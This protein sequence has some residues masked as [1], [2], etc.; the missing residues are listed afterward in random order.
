MQ[1]H[2]WDSAEQLRLLSSSSPHRITKWALVLHSPLLRVPRFWNSVMTS[3]HKG[4]NRPRLF[5]SGFLPVYSA[6]L[7]APSF[8]PP[9]WLNTLDPKPIYPHTLSQIRVKPE[10]VPCVRASGPGGLCGGPALGGWH[11]TSQS[12][13]PRPPPH[14][15]SAR[16]CG[17]WVM[18]E[19]YPQ[20]SPP[21]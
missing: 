9:F 21:S 10:P 1:S 18:Q 6:E 13:A 4:G 3:D 8:Q 11:S 2:G 16:S 12:A 5:A 15:L 14:P 17:G 19:A 20:L 7:P